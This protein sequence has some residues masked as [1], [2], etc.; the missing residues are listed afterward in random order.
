MKNFFREMLLDA[1][2]NKEI[3]EWVSKFEKNLDKA[4]AEYWKKMFDAVEKY[5]A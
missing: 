1:P 5:Y 3:K 2:K 4:S